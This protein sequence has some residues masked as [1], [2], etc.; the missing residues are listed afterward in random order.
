MS[1]EKIQNENPDQDL[2]KETTAEESAQDNAGVPVAEATE[3]LSAEE[4][5]QKKVDELN[6]RYLRL[7]AEFDNY[8]KRTHKEK[9][10]TLKNA[11]EDIFKEMLPV[12]DDFER[13]LAHMSTVTD[14]DAL[15]EG[16]DLIYKKFVEFLSRR[17]VSAIE[18][19]DAAFDVD[20]MEAIAK[21]PATDETMKGKVFD[22][23]EKGYKL[24]DK[25]IRFAKVVV[26]E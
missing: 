4:A 11:G 22:C 20:V 14:V 24:G 2:Q 23:V 5:L 19:K 10:E 16:V 18:V 6:D 1:K 7:S 8:R 21:M 26:C 12:I 15:R 3:T 25:V 17:G 9:I 13:G